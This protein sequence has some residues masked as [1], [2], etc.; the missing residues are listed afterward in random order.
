MKNIKHV[1]GG[2]IPF[3]ALAYKLIPIRQQYSPAAKKMLQQYGN[4]T[5]KAITIF[6]KPIQSFIGTTLN[7]A[8]ANDFGRAAKK[9]GQDT[10]FHLYMVVAITTS[11]TTQTTILIE[12][13]EI[14]GIKMASQSDMLREN[15]SSMQIID[16]PVPQGL[17]I[18]TMLQNTL[19]QMGKDQYWSY[20]PFTNNCQSYIKA[21]LGANNMM[22]QQLLDFI[23]QPAD[24]IARE[25][26]SA[27]VR[28]GASF[29]TNLASKLR[30]IQYLG[31]GL[32]LY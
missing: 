25:S 18:N 9:Y 5:I 16:P 15:G 21:I 26:L 32:E 30:S 29:I 17:T 14:I 1:Q 27:P 11:A 22:N 10:L 6:R 28:Q 8:S 13:N 31:R 12:K 23:V 19:N 20:D 24:A 3:A 4:F 2:I 7:L